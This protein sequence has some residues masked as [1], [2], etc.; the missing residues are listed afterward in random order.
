V[1]PEYLIN[2][3]ELQI[4][5]AQG[6]KPGEGGQL[7]GTKVSPLIASLRHTLPGVTLISPPPHHDIYSIEDL[8]QL[9]FDL[10]QINPNAKVSVKLASIAGVGTIAAGVVKAYADKILISGYDGGTGAAQLSSIKHAGNPWELGLSE[11]HHTLKANNLRSSVELQTDGGLKTGLDVVKAALLGA[12][13]YGFGTVLLNT[14]GCK[15]LRICHLNKCSVGIATQ[16]EKLRGYYTGAVNGVVAYLTNVAEEVREILASMGYSS[17]EEI[18]GRADLLKALDS[19]KANKFDFSELLLPT[20]GINICTKE[21]NVPFDKNIFEKNIFETHQEAIL[22]SSEPIF[23]EDTIANVNRSFGTYISGKI[24]K[25][26]GD[27]GLP[28]DLL[29]IT[30]SGNAGQSFGAFLSQGMSL[31]LKGNANDYVGKGMHGGRIVI[32]PSHLNSKGSIAGNTCLYGA[33]GGKLFIAGSA[34]E[35]FAVRNSGALAVVEGTGDHACEYM[36]GGTVVILGPTGIN[37]GAGFTGGAAFVYDKEMEF[38]DKAN[39]EL[40]KLVR[41]DTDEGEEGRHYLRKI[42]KSYWKRTNSE[43]ARRILDNFLSELRY[44]WL[45]TPKDMKSPLNPF[46]EN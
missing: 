42:L 25:K 33:T 27:K 4:K 22:N 39:M 18:I 17:L 6:A 14:L 29:N 19:P 36:T 28:K 41:I 23:I 9:I 20:T 35:R 13:T 5:L 38:F 37:F 30:L 1:T 24:A 8:A 43:K 45:V 32:V 16:D 46:E 7:P 15:I 21:N 31:L 26:Y 34:G 44:F 10:K 40:I 2:A 12:E 11:A 3:E